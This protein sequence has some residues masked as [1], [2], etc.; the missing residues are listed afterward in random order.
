MMIDSFLNEKESSHS[1]YCIHINPMTNPVTHQSVFGGK[2]MPIVR[3]YYIFLMSFSREFIPRVKVKK[4]GS[5]NMYHYSKPAPNETH[6]DA[7]ENE[8]KVG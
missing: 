4:I 3:V 7:H 1:F 8:I 2:F 5:L 6:L